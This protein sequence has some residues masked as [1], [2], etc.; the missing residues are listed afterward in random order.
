MRTDDNRNP[1]AFTVDLARQAGLVM[2]TDYENGS[3]FPRGPEITAKILG[4]PVEVTIRLI[5]AVGYRQTRAPFLP[6]WSYICLPKFLWDAL[7]D[8]PTPGM[9]SKRDVIGYH[10]QQ[11]GNNGS[12]KALFPNYGMK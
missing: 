6:R 4:D 11:E 10:Y 8:E 3:A 9:V 5:N 12:M 2:G 7:P 1:A